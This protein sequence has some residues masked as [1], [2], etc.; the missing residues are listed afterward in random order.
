MKHDESNPYECKTCL[1]VFASKSHLK[2]HSRCHT[3]EKPFVC[4]TC[5]K[6]FATKSTLKAHKA[7]HSEE[8]KYKCA[9]CTEE[10]FFKTK[11]GLSHHMKY[12][13]EPTY[14]CKKCGK[15]FHRSSDLRRHEKSNF[16]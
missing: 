11:S 1:K 16:C 15:K 3:G 7:I 5:G 13:S 6:G 9:V 8:R 14:G 4:S 2:V 10:K 12:H